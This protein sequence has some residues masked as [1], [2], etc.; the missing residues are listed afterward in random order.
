METNVIMRDTSYDPN[1]GFYLTQRIS[2]ASQ[3]VFNLITV[4]IFTFSF[5]FYCANYLL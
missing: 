2:I 1:S 4:K 3:R 5:I